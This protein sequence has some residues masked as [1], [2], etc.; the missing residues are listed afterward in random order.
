M[1]KFDEEAID[2]HE[3]DSIVRYVQYTKSP[4]DRGGWAIG[5]LGPIPEGLVAWLILVAVLLTV[6]RLLGERS[7]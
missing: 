5:H 4:D 7:E 6:V 2:E 1:P 3:L